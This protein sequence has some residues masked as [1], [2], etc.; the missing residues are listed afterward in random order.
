MASAC[1]EYN[2]CSVKADLAVAKGKTLEYYKKEAEMDGKAISDFRLPKFTATD[3]EGNKVTS[4]DL[5]GQPTVLVLLASHCGHSYKSLP[6]L[7]QA[8][9]EF[10]AKGLRVVGLMVNSDAKS[11]KAWFDKDEINHEVWFTDDASVADALKSHL[12]PTYVL[13]DA[14]GYIKAKLVG[15][16]KGEEV[17]QS[18]PPLLVQA[19]SNQDNQEG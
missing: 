12:V 9:A 18:I 7:E 4:A 10:E 11:T 8:A 17:N 15:F 19:E 14:D 13:V 16:K 5:I 2:A 1:A 3:I 6:I